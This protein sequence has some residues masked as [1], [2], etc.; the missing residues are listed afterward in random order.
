MKIPYKFNKE[1]FDETAK[2][3]KEPEKSLEELLKN[4]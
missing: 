3:T 4:Y 2:R 1:S